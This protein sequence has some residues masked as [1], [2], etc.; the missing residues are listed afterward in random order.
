MNAKEHL[1][2][3]LDS[4]DRKWIRS[5]A[6]ALADHVGWLKVGLEAFSGHGPALVEELADYGPRIFLDLKLHD[7]PATVKRA[8]ANCAA[9]GASML[10]VHAA[11][12]RRML[13]AAIE[14][15]HQGG[16]KKP[17]KIV[18]VTVLTSLDSTALGELEINETPADLVG[19]WAVLASESGLDGVVASA[20]EAAALR[21]AF[22]AGFLIV[23]PGIRPASSA[24]DDQRRVMTPTEAVQAG[25]DIL[26]VGRP[27]TGADDPVEAAESIV[28]EMSATD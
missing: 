21:R 19:A 26:V 20:H 11:G 22:G 16:K 18:A 7:I 1:C 8:A 14:G 27:I 10:T 28:E 4:S 12:G 5:T 17:P 25:A 13:E 6:A 2:V 3:A 15:A 24:T 9:C 23:T